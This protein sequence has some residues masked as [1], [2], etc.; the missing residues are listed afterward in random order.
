[1]KK[2]M[3]RLMLSCKKAT[4]L[5]EKKGFVRLSNVE[6]IQLFMH[7]RMCDACGRYAKQSKLIDKVLR[8]DSMP[9]DCTKHIPPKVLSVEMKARIINNLEKK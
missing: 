2:L 1:M 7:T 3:N 5:M 4:E 8:Q 9:E 6:R